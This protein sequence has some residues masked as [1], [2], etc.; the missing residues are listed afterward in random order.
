[1]VTLAAETTF[2]VFDKIFHQVVHKEATTQTHTD[3]LIPSSNVCDYQPPFVVT[4]VLALKG[5]TPTA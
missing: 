1:M 5:N 3:G 4:E 2:V